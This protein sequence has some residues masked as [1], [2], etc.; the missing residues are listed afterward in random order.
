MTADWPAD[1][2]GPM[3]GVGPRLR[4]AV[5]A[6]AALV[7]AAGDV[8][9]G[10]AALLAP[11]EA[12]ARSERAGRWGADVDVLLAERARL[13]RGTTIDV[14]LP[15]QLSVSQLV[16]LQ[17]DPGELARRIHRPLPAA[18]APWARRGTAFHEWLERR[19][20]MPVAAGRRRAA[21][22]R[23]RRRRRG[24]RPRRAAGGVRGQRVG[25][26]H[27]DRGRGAVRDDGDGRVVRGRM[28]AVFGSAEDGWLVVDWKTGSRPR[29]AA[30]RAAEVQLAAYRL[31][32]AR[33]HG[34][35][36]A[37][38]DRVRPRSTTSAPTRPSSPRDL[39]DAA[40]L[41]ELVAGGV[42]ADE[43]VG[44]PAG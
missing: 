1:P 43:A 15:D 18:P 33:L 6:G 12:D 44:S 30:A 36:D 22:R 11:G 25:H 39:L 21:R 41:R 42:Q 8:L 26:P 23:R 37:E 9:P 31:A 38:L 3:G 5:E 28:D 16:E 35:A 27:A 29:G 4:P 34:I 2:L 32:W 10:M 14:E 20:T 19:W 13:Q 17:R 24:A 7:R 40:G